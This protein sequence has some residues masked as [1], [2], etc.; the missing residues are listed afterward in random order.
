MSSFANTVGGDLLLGVDEHAGTATAVEG[1]EVDDLG[2]LKLR[3]NQLMASWHGPTS[4]RFHPANIHYNGPSPSN[5]SVIGY[6]AGI[7]R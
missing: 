7:S 6:R 1:I 3:M 2:A 4:V 5:K